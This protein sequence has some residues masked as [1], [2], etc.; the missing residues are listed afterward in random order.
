MRFRFCCWATFPFLW[1]AAVL[2]QGAR[3]LLPV[4]TSSPQA[5]LR[6]FYELTDA[7]EASSLAL[8]AAPTAA[9]QAEVESL[10]QKAISLFDLNKVPPLARREAG[11]DALVFL[12]DVLR[13]VEVPALESI[14]DA[15]AFPD[16]EKPASWTIPGTEI[17]IARLLHGPKR[18]KFVFDAETVARAGEFYSLVRNLPL[19]VPARVQSWREEQLQLHGWMIPNGW[20]EALPQAL[21]IPFLD[22]PAW[23]V[24]GTTVVILLLAGM[25]ALWRRMIAPKPDDYGAL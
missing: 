19:R 10:A 17:V 24:L 2:A 8:K 25:L 4:D 7:L 13:R 6:T 22:T 11:G 21:K 3:P 15:T 5:T 9:Q 20:I 12:V 16:L 23:K 18:A 14:P 1:P